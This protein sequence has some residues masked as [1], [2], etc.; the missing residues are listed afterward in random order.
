MNKIIDYVFEN[1]AS[2]SEFTEFCPIKYD[3]FKLVGRC[4]SEKKE[5]SEELKKWYFTESENRN[6]QINK[7]VNCA[8][9]NMQISCAGRKG[10]FCPM[11]K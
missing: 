9:C 2:Y 4:I 6:Q 5:V 1:T 11:R 8:K 10:D 7:S 3:K